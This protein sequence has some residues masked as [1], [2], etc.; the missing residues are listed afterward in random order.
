M[1][2]KSDNYQNNFDYTDSTLSSQTGMV[3]FH[4]SQ[5]EGLEYY[6]RF[7]DEDGN[8]VLYSQSYDK[9]PNR[10][11]GIKSVLKNADIA[12]RY[13]VLEEDGKWFVALRAG[14][15]QEIA[16]TGAISKKKAAEKKAKWLAANLTSIDSVKSAT[17]P[18]EETISEATATEM[19]VDAA[20]TTNDP[21]YA[22]RIDLYPRQDEELA[23]VITNILDNKNEKFRGVDSVAIT[24]FIV[25]NLSA[26]EK[27]MLPKPKVADSVEETKDAVAEEA[28]PESKTALQENENI[29]IELVENPESE[30][31]GNWTTD[32]FINV[33]LKLKEGIDLP[34]GKKINM[35]MF[36]YPLLNPEMKIEVS[37]QANFTDGDTAFIKDLQRLKTP[38]LYRLNAIS[39]DGQ[40]CGPLYGTK[41]INVYN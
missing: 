37:T 39:M 16:R 6:F 31:Q 14:N 5:E 10:D 4:I 1:S 38:G 20:V 35:N 41:L 29:T 32:E 26:K 24:N 21:K 27:E 2:Q 9:E 7:N 15:H 3:S 23:G 8:P 28:K 34:S 17:P 11:N 30:H 19:E 40:E 18:V 33:R 12:K 13:K 25:S 36:M 22:F